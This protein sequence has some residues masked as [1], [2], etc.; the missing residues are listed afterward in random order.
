MRIEEQTMG[1]SYTV[2]E[3]ARNSGINVVMYGGRRKVEGTRTPMPLTVAKELPTSGK[4]AKTK[5]LKVIIC[6][7]GGIGKTALVS[8]F[9]D[10]QFMPDTKMT[11]AVQFHTVRYTF[12]NDKDENEVALQIW[13]LGGQKHFREMGM[14][15]K[16]CRGA[17]VAMVCF[18]LSDLDTL[19]QVPGWIE[20]L[21]AH[22]PKILVGTKKDQSYE[23]AEDIVEPFLKEFNFQGYIETSAKDESD[24]VLLA[25]EKLMAAYKESQVSTMPLVTAISN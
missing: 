17:H 2:S 1:R 24:S 13:D 6:G 25:F 15:E 4:R 21:P 19:E 11:I 20:L 10:G 7:E 5:S 12:T 8:T 9:R 18:D 22:I 16:Y 3:K 23:S 14:F